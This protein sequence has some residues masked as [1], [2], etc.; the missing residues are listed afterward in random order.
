VVSG[1]AHDRAVAAVFVVL[2]LAEIVA[3][4]RALCFYRR[5]A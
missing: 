3:A 5:V 2:W 4:W 1:T